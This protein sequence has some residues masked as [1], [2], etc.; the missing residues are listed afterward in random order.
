[1]LRGIK[2]YL[3]CSS[4]LLL[5]IECYRPLTSCINLLISSAINGVADNEKYA[6]SDVSQLISATVQ[7]GVV[8]LQNHQINQTLHIYDVDGAISFEVVNNIDEKISNQDSNTTTFE[9]IFGIYKL[10]ASYC[11][12][13][14]KNSEPAASFFGGFYGVRR[15]T[16]ISF[17]NVPSKNSIDNDTVF[18][19]SQ[20]AIDLEKQKKALL[21][22]QDSLSRH[23]FYFSTGNFDITR[24]MQ[25]NAIDSMVFNSSKPIP[26][27]FLHVA[28]ASFPFDW[29][30]CDERFFWN[31]NVIS[32]LTRVPDLNDH[33][34]TPITNAWIGTKVL[35]M[36]LRDH[37]DKVKRVK[38]GLTLI[39]RRS[40]HRQGPRLVTNSDEIHCSTTCCIMHIL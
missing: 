20:L 3:L 2:A 13:F 12:A 7:D 16:E 19:A 32:D 21:L 11:I 14:V 9:K 17:I 5:K 36:K 28:E 15:V 35:P 38:F 10:P 23:S 39:S 18:N 37:N 22:M 29:R 31:L 26:E 8:F 1:M 25:A 27:N 30:S 33:W 34:I 6:T 4:L 24:S 40:R